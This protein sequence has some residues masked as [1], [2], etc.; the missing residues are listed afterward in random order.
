LHDILGL[1][2]RFTPRF[3]KKYVDLSAEIEHALTQYRDE[4]HAGAFP[5]PENSTAIDD[6]EFDAWIGAG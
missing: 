5:G 2:D 3:A 1:Y 4:V 6:A